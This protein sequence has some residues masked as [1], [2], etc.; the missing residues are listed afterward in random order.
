MI[1]YPSHCN[2]CNS[3]RNRWSEDITDSEG[4]KIRYKTTFRQ[5]YK[6][7]YKTTITRPLNSCSECVN[8][9][10]FTF[11]LSVDKLPL[12]IHLVLNWRP[13]VSPIISELKSH[14]MSVSVALVKRKL[15]ATLQTNTLAPNQLHCSTET[16]NIESNYRHH[17][18]YVVILH[19]G[20]VANGMAFPGVE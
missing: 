7:R 6:I 20:G 14:T 11:N 1:H 9:M 15:C 3:P 4:C 16:W 2:K 12:T 13:L 19:R 5:R 17:S 10:T 18:M 8:P